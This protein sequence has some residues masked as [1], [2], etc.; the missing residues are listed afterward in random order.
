MQLYCAHL[1][2]HGLSIKFGTDGHA[3]R[4]DFF[5]KRVSLIPFTTFLRLETK[6]TLD[7]MICRRLL[8]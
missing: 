6:Y 2:M 5:Y 3:R 4:P 1:T 7:L 8:C